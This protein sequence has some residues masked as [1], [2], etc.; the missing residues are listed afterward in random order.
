M[1]LFFCMTIVSSLV[2]RSY[3][4]LL[5]LGLRQLTNTR[6]STTDLPVGLQSFRCSKEKKTGI[7]PDLGADC[8]AVSFIASIISIPLHFT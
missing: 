4:S 1:P 6:N 5:L 8:V 3:V 7:L 2:D